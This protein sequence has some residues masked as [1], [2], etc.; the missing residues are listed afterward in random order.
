MTEEDGVKRHKSSLVEVVGLVVAGEEDLHF[1]P[2]RSSHE[3]P[4][5]ITSICKLLDLHK[6][7][8]NLVRIPS[9]MA[10]DSELLTVHS[11]Q[12]LAKLHRLS[13]SLDHAECNL[14]AQEEFESIYMNK[15]SLLAAKLSAGSAL[16]MLDAVFDHHP[17]LHRA[18]AAIRPPGHHAEHH[19]AMGFCFFN[20]AALVVKRALDVHSLAKVLIVDFDIH[21]GNAT[22]RMFF[23][24]DRV[25]YFSI[26]RWDRGKFYPAMGMEA[27]P[28]VTGPSGKTVNVAF[29]DGEMGDLEYRAV[30]EAI[31]VPLVGEF[32]PELVVFSAGFDVLHGD[33]IGRYH[34][35]PQGL[36]CLVHHTLQAAVATNQRSKAV[37]LLEGGYSNA[38]TAEGFCA[39][40]KAMHSN[41]EGEEWPEF[42]LWPRTKPQALEAIN[43]TIAA[44]QKFWR[45]L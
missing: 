22:Q 32:S 5:R 45:S 24:D 25:V 35:S 17:H 15:N 14:Q 44:H 6:A 41:S 29:S 4:S 38:A 42:T 39:C 12:Y 16:T 2:G 33:P 8:M 40:V 37:L 7:E 19:C 34:V 23:N 13:Q 21:H 20:N 18:A 1:D 27:S 3:K 10:L 43:A 28:Q 9:R 26:H 30:V 11:K 31:L 36:G